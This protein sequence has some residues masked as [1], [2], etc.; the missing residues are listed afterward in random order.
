MTGPR[1]DLRKRPDGPPP[2]RGKCVVTTAACAVLALALGTAAGISWWTGGSAALGDGRFGTAVVCGAVVLLCA[3]LLAVR[4][5]HFTARSVWATSAAFTLVCLLG[6]AVCW[7]AILHDDGQRLVAGRMLHDE[8]DAGAYLARNM[9]EGR[10]PVVVPTGLYVES[11]E[12]T[13]SNNVA[14]SGYVWQRYPANTPKDITRGVVFP[15]ADSSYL[16][17]DDIAYRRTAADGTE[18]V[19]WY[20]STA[21]RQRFDYRTYPMDRQNVWLRMWQPD[22]DKDVVLT[23]DFSAYPPWQKK[24]MLGTDPQ[25]VSGEWRP[26]YTG[27][28]YARYQYPTSFGLKTY[29][30]P[31]SYPDLYFNM[32]YQRNYT[33]AVI[34]NLV[35]VALIALVVFASLFVTSRD[36]K[37]E[38]FGS[39]TFA[40]MAFLVTMLLVVVVDHNELRSV[41]GDGSVMYMEYVYFAVY[42]LLLLVT[43]NGVLI[44]LDRPGEILTKQAN[45]PAK[46]LY[47]PILA[48][49]VLTATV[50]VFFGVGW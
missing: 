24:E 19:G 46:A 38:L 11:I 9:P 29:D 22:F 3:V 17:D 13:N 35:P 37:I 42:V 6:T 16:E 23:P 41:S 30:R 10:S 33:G 7:V 39:N 36:Q 2:Y 4:P 32:V 48:V 40:V 50:G 12:F 21:F 44:A 47:W 1:V 18:T 5:W 34:G 49:I 27:F 28:S 20:F 45:L 8:R 14:V 26:M 43:A 25:M 15:E 31:V